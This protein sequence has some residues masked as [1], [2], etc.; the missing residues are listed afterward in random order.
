MPPFSGALFREVSPGLETQQD[1]TVINQIHGDSGHRIKD[2]NI[3]EK[4]PKG[5]G[6]GAG[7]ET[8]AIDSGACDNIAH[9]SAFPNTKIEHNEQ[10]GR[11]YG[12]CGGNAVTN[13][14]TKHVT[15]ATEEH[16]VKSI[17]FHIGDEITHAL[18]VVSSVV[19]CRKYSHVWASP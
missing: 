5:W 9:P 1:N 8:A 14:G 18:V 7:Y 17:K 16:I 10:T 19:R 13:I 2:I 6:A 3:P 12:A 4:L 11:K 15:F